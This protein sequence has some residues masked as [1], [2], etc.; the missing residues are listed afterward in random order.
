MLEPPP[1][2]TGDKVRLKTGSSPIMV[3]EV[4]YFTC[5]CPKTTPPKRKKYTRPRKGWW[6]RFMYCSAMTYGCCNE[7]EHRTWREAEDF[8]FFDPQEAQMPTLYQTTD[9]KPRYGTFLTKDSQGRFVLE[10][11]GGG[12]VEAFDPA[13]IEEVLPHTV[14]LTRF[15][16]G[17]AGGETRHYQIAEGQVKVGDVLLHLSNGNLWE[18]T[19]VN[20]KSK[21]NHTSKNGFL[22]LEGKRVHTDN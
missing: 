15:E 18:V 4:D 20:T 5:S 9:K 8:V 3:L 14:E 13:D 10:M 22:I 16:G 12:G 6:I 17:S 7:A 1:F 19:A 21:T 2:K 11:K